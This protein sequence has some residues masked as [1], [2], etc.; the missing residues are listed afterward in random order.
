MCVNGI[1]FVLINMDIF[2]CWI[3]NIFLL[4][5]SVVVAFL[6][7]L[8]VCLSFELHPLNIDYSL[9]TAQVIVLL[10]RRKGGKLENRTGRPKVYQQRHLT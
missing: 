1:D 6:A 8:P 3:L 2:R 5:P 10:V 9:V 4:P 7:T